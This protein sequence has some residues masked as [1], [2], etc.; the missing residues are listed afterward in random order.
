MSRPSLAKQLAIAAAVL[1]LLAVSIALVIIRGPDWG[2]VGTSF[3]AVRWYWVVI[4]LCLNFLSIVVRALA[5]KTVIDQA[6]EP[7][8]PGHRAVFS[9]FSVGLF[10][11]AV[12]PGRIGELA[13]VAVLTRRFNGRKGAWA[14]LVGTVFAHRVFD[15]FPVLVLVAFVLQT[16][17]IPDWAH[18]A[19]KLFVFLAALLFLVAFVFATR[20]RGSPLDGLGPVRRLLRMARYGLTVMHT[21]AAAGVAIAFQISGWL[22]QLLAVY[23]TMRAFEIHA[24]L[25]AAAMVLLLMNIAT[26]FPLWPG[27][28]GLV[29]AA[30][31]VPL[32]SY[33]VAIAHGIAFGFGLQAIEASV[34]I[35]LGMTFLAREGISYATLKGMPEATEIELQGE[36]SGDPGRPVEK[37]EAERKPRSKRR[38]K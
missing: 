5:W 19:L 8:R 23:S 12:L 20:R 2:K 25:S 17:Q 21:P 28:I 10:G 24:P 31:A 16:A 4:A 27:N 35:G 14:T 32:A 38:L 11:N 9:A 18:A 3:A 6:L 26:V 7:P 15:L 33:G 34:G 37:R 22:L 36:S 30:I 13:R 1:A 29:Q